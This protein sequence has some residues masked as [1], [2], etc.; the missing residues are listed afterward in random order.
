MIHFFQAISKLDIY[1]RTLHSD[2]HMGA[3]LRAL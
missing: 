2:V 3:A 1:V